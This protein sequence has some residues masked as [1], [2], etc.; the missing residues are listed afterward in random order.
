MAS[1]LGDFCAPIRGI[2]PT[3]S[4]FIYDIASKAHF[5]S[6]D[7]S[8]YIGG[9][10]DADEVKS[11]SK[12]VFGDGSC[13]QHTQNGVEF[14]S[15]LL[16]Y[17]L[18]ITKASLFNNDPDDVNSVL[19]IGPGA[20]Q[21]IE[22]EVDLKQPNSQRGDLYD[23]SHSPFKMTADKFKSFDIIF[24]FVYHLYHCVVA[25]ILPGSR[26]IVV[27]D[28]LGPP[29][30]N[31]HHTRVC[32]AWTADIL[33]EEKAKQWKVAAHP[34]TMVQNGGC[35]S[36]GAMAAI[37]IRCLAFGIS[38]P[39]VTRAQILTEVL[40]ER[41]VRCRRRVNLEVLAGRLNPT[42][43]HLQDIKSRILPGVALGPLTSTVPAGTC[44][45]WRR[46]CCRIG[47]WI[48]R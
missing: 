24:V 15:N 16:D 12:L 17:Y 18:D 8:L 22:S 3:Q 4:E 30:P 46:S 2:S 11:A 34:H 21:F 42:V 38:F 19:I 28:S 9:V 36:C 25:S 35:N 32:Q 45:S 26:R 1:K 20:F 14:A 7:E 39:P 33:G 5:V 23:I 48:G 37:T 43:A 47:N 27:Y 40:G 31:P 29:A 13:A 44:R 10:V 41:D 6:Q